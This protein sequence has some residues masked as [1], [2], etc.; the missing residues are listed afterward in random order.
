MSEEAG[1]APTAA[2]ADG[3]VADYTMGDAP[4]DVETAEEESVD[5][6][7]PAATGATATAAPQQREVNKTAAEL[8][9]AEEKRKARSDWG[10]N[11]G[12]VLQRV[13]WISPSTSD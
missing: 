6:E 11:G 9:A 5:A 12:S 10:L 13:G 3:A 4:P 7:P 8:V 1:A 2:S